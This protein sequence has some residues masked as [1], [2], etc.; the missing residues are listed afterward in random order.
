MPESK[1]VEEKLV[2][3]HIHI[4]DHT[5]VELMMKYFR[6]EDYDSMAKYAQKIGLKID[7]ANT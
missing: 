6:F 7:P 5:A 2:S 1:K 4:I 3:S